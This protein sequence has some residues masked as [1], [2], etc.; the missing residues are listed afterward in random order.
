VEPRCTD[1]NGRSRIKEEHE[2]K[3]VT[4]ITLALVAAAIGASGAG[5]VAGTPPDAFERAVIRHQATEPGYLERADDHYRTL[6]NRPSV[7]V[8]YTLDPAIAAAMQAR[9]A[10][11]DLSDGRSPDT[12]DAGLRAQAQI[13]QVVIGNGFDWGDFG[14]GAGS[15]L[16]LLVCAGGL[17]VAARAVGSKRA[18][19]SAA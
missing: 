13:G 5:A 3:L 1:R 9:Q 4:T 14:I 18:R 2:M 8:D 15:M 11:P 16:G 19:P 12:I 6:R 17:R 10:T 7:R